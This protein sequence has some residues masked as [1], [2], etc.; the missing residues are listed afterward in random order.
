MK[1]KINW[2]NVTL[3]NKVIAKKISKAISSKQLSHGKIVDSFEKKLSN[4]LQI[5]Y[6]ACTNSG[7]NALLLL[8]VSLNLKKN[9]EVILPNRTWISDLNAVKLLKLKIKLVDVQK[10]SPIIC[11][12]DLKKKISKKTKVVIAVHMGGRIADL[13]KIYKLTK[14]NKIILI[15]DACQALRPNF[16]NNLIGKYSDA[17]FYSLSV[18]KLITSG[19][20]GFIATSN[21]KLFS[22]I[23]L[24]RFNG[25]RIINDCEK[26]TSLGF[27]FKFTDLLATV[28]ISELEKIKLKIKK[29]NFLYK[30]YKKYIDKL[31]YIKIIPIN[32][33]SG[34]I[35]IYIEVTCVYRRKLINFLKKN[36]V[37]SRSFYPSLNEAIYNKEE[38]KFVNSDHFSNNGLYLPSGPDLKI[39]SVKKIIFLLKNFDDQISA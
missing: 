29:L 13:E 25:V 35:P 12:K 26:W 39:Q 30:L 10:D 8:L 18:A 15:E 17:C 4:I 36:L 24:N 9:D 22:K 23:I 31:N 32:L 37:D 1:K 27:N 33:N 34:E 20:G 2:W 3:N 6:V 38:K 14:K 21:K 16:K 19:Q 7:S 5:P 11:V 28:G